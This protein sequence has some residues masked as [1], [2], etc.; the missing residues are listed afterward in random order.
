VIAHYEQGP[1]LFRKRVAEL[2]VIFVLQKSLADIVLCRHG[3]VRHT[4]D[5]RRVRFGGKANFDRFSV[6][7]VFSPKASYAADHKLFTGIRKELYRTLVNLSSWS[8]LEHL[9]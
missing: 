9:D 3:E 7:I 6:Q 5:L 1:N 2:A 4:D 8:F